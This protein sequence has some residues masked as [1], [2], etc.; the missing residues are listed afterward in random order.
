MI[1][2]NC[3]SPLGPEDRFCS[4]CGA[5]APEELPPQQSPQPAAPPSPQSAPPSEPGKQ[6]PIGSEKGINPIL[7]VV[8]I[9]VVLCCGF[10]AVIYVLNEFGLL[11]NLA[12][13]LNL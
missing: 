2:N 13:E 4:E 10:M 9:L 3:N 7:V 6:A 11:D 5:A 1:C 12:W 8:V